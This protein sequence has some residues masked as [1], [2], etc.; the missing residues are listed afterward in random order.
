MKLWIDPNNGL[1][2]LEPLPGY[3]TEEDKIEFRL[4]DDVTVLQEE[5]TAT[6][7]TEQATILFR[8]DG[9]VDPG[10]TERLVLQGRWNKNHRL[11]IVRDTRKQ[12]YVIEQ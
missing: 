7:K 1:C 8:P 9:T 10:S 12:R 4:A 5:K 3:G 2:G 6:D 11:T